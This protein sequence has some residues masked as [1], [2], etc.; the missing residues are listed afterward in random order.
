MKNFFYLAVLIILFNNI[1]NAEITCYQVVAGWNLVGSPCDGAISSIVTTDPPGIII[2]PWY[3][4]SGGYQQATTLTAAEGYWVKVIQAGTICFDC[5]CGSVIPNCGTVD[6]GGKI[7][8][9]V[10]IGTQCWLRENLDIGT[11]ILGNQNQTNN[12]TIEKY[13]YND[14]S[15]NCV[16]FGGLYQWDEAMQYPDPPITYPIQ[17]IC[18]PGWHYPQYAE[19][20]QLSAVVGGD[21]NA[22]KALGHGVGSGVGTNTSGFTA[23][24]AGDRKVDGTFENLG[25]YVNMST[26]TE[27]GTEVW[28]V[29]L[30][31]NSS[32][33][34]FG[35]INK[36]LGFSV[37]CV[38]D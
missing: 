30:P 16:L 2:S 38:K 25:L 34:F 10:Y 28:G 35:G 31:T 29:G 14:I 20:Q 17:G 33:I 6:Y 21:G 26:S 24:L 9:T 13:C 22:L 36:Q 32:G 7:Y 37:R 3:R 1:I 4:Y 5:P 11:M 27:N 19:F 15:Y 12:S 8:N 18:P 23:L